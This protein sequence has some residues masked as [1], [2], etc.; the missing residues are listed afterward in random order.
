MVNAR[1]VPAAENRRRY[2]RIDGKYVVRHE[3][4][5]IPRG[6]EAQEAEARNISANGLLFEAKAMYPPGTVLRLELL[7]QGIDKF[8]TEFYKHERLSDTEPFVV[9]GKVARVE[10]VREGVYDIG[11]SLVGVD[12]QHQKALARYIDACVKSGRPAEKA[13]GAL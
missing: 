3:R 5:T 7:V 1:T 10:A 11:V 4:L 12:Q 13:G 8:K 6:R 9:L 2:L